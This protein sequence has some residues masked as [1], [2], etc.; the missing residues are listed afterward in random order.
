VVDLINQR[1]TVETTRLVPSGEK[2]RAAIADIIKSAYE[3]GDTGA[4]YHAGHVQEK[5]LVGRLFAV[6]FLQTNLDSDYDIAIENMANSLKGEIQD[7][8]RKLQNP[9]LRDMLKAFEYAHT[10]YVQAMRDIIVEKITSSKI[11]LM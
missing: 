7:L 1:N 4:V 3:D 8:D 6:K 9:K 5:M 11:P 2:M 10:G